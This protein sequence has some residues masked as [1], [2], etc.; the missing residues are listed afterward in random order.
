MCPG[1]DIVAATRTNNHRR[2]IGPLFAGP[3]YGQGG[4]IHI[5]NTRLAG[6]V[7]RCWPLAF[8]NAGRFIR[9]P[10]LGPDLKLRMSAISTGKQS[11]KE[12]GIGKRK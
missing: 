6:F 10:V 2:T 3:V 11:Q 4:P 7:S 1:Q 5:G 8:F 12:S 9:N